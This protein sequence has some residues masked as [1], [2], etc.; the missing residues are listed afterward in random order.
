MR[1]ML[2][3]RYE[4]TTS[5]LP[6]QT[7]FGAMHVAKNYILYGNTIKHVELIDTHTAEIIWER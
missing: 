4:K 6:F 1:Y 5:Y 2:V 3:V 7:E